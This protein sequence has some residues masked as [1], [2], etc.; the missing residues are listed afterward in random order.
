MGLGLG[1]ALAGPG[2]LA[3]N[4]TLSA[5]QGYLFCQGII[6][7]PALPKEQS[8]LCFPILPIPQANG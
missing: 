6:M 4:Y 1:L 8:K 3:L 2:A 7:V 5:S